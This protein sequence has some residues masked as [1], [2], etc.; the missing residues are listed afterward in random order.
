[1]NVKSSCGFLHGFFRFINERGF[2]MLMHQI[3]LCLILL[4]LI[5]L[6]LSKMTAA[7]RVYKPKHLANEA[8]AVSE[9]DE[10]DERWWREVFDY[11][12]G[13]TDQKG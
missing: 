6:A 10:V 13:Y 1:M 3:A 7:Y 5:S 11:W 9:H 8:P 12:D 4:G 2:P